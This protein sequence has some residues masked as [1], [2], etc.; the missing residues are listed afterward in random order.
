MVRNLH[1]YLT[2]IH[3]CW[4][5]LVIR[6]GL[7]SGKLSQTTQTLHI[8]RSTARTFEREQWEALEKRLIAWKSGLASVLEV[9]ATARASSSRRGGSTS[10]VGAGA[11]ESKD[12]NVSEVGKREVAAV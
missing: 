12:G 4:Q 11:G 3:S 2:C 1:L 8:S 5:T 6:V 9:V 10:N 7:V